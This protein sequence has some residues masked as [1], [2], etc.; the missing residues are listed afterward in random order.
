MIGGGWIYTSPNGPPFLGGATITI[1][2]VDGSVVTSLSGEDG[3][4]QIRDQVKPPY[5]VCASECPGTNCSLIA[6]PSADCQTSNCHGKRGQRIYVASGA[7]NTQDA[8]SAAT[9]DGGTG[10]CTPPTSGGP[11][12][13]NEPVFGNQPCSGG[14]C[15]RAPK[16]VFQGGF[17]YD[18]PTSTTT[19]GEA[20]VTVTPSSGN[21]LKMVT[22]IDGMFFVGTIGDETTP[23]A[24]TPPYTVCVS[25]CPTTICSTK[26]GHTTT[27]DC[28]TSGCHD[29]YM[30]VY[31]K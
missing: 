30:K 6:H 29:S 25:K 1:Y 8:G 20:T 16:T 24:L 2:N 22:G 12:T 26:N 18:G 15:H 23:V 14:G 9:W 27:T 17:L 5:K 10:N 11:Y 7:S 31:L 28:Q 13:H 21:P 4:F 19:V 3:F